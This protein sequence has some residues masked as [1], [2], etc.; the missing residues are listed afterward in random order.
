ML[1]VDLSA[2]GKAA[3]TLQCPQGKL[4]EKHECELRYRYDSI[5][6]TTCQRWVHI[7]Y[8]MM[9][10]IHLTSQP[11]QRVDPEPDPETTPVPESFSANS[12]TSGIDLLLPSKASC[13]KDIVLSMLLL[14][15]LGL[16]IVV[17]RLA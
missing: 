12:E 1:D 13:I 5:D 17:P 10:S 16:V 8:S 14:L 2:Y 9:K 3:L 11:N 7:Q 6:V 4:W 15:V